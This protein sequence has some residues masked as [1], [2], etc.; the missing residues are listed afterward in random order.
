MGASSGAGKGEGASIVYNKEIGGP[1]KVAPKR[2][3]T[4]I[5]KLSPIPNV[6]L[7]G[8]LLL[9]DTDET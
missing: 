2:R 9:K 3:K 4:V 5:E 7:E 1:M 8:I 6:S